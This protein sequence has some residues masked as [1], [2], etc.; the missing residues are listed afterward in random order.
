LS[1]ASWYRW[2]GPDLVLNLR[3]QPRA[4]RDAFGEPL[5]DQIKV[6]IMAPPVEGKANAHLLRFI[7]DAC[8]VPLT[9]VFLLA[10]G[11]NRAKRLRVVAPRRLPAGVLA[12]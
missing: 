2:E 7:A 9:Q 10:G 1:Q 6:R 4:R 5:G 8:G 11:Q 12:P 3:V